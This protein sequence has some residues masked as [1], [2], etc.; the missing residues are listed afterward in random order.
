VGGCVGRPQKHAT[1]GHTIVMEIWEDLRQIVDGNIGSFQVHLP[2]HL[3]PFNRACCSLAW[4]R[5]HPMRASIASSGSQAG[6]KLE[7]SVRSACQKSP[8]HLLWTKE[9]SKTL[10]CVALN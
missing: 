8:K 4:K 9:C 10:Q 2:V 6:H 3:A 5:A 7:R 1:T